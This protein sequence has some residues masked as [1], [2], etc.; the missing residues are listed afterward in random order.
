MM[1]DT[2]QQEWPNRR[3]EILVPTT[4]LCVLS[5][6]VLVWR[7]VYGLKNKRKLLV[8]DYLLIIAAMM[9]ITTNGLRFKTTHHGQGRHIKDPSI[10]KPHDLLQYSYYLWIGQ[11]INLM[12]VAVLKFSVCAYLL[13]LKFSR[14]YLGII[15]TSILMVTVFNL[16]I[17]IMSVFCRVPFEANWN[18]GIK[19][20]CFMK[21]PGLGIA[22]SQGISNI[23]TDVVYVV[24]PLIY[25]NTIRLARR[26]Q[27]GLRVVF[28]LG[29]V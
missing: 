23:L 17:P 21:V 3:L 10:S 15:W 24:A 9:N 4:I 6:L 8:C 29:L 2:Q 13:A 18:K 27:W 26:T 22:Y 14:L 19:G 25:L 20:K 5:T 11:V 12:A 7:V 16:T 1:V 28:C